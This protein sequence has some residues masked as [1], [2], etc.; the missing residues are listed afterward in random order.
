MNLSSIFKNNALAA[1]FFLIVAAC[2]YLFYLQ[3]Y[4]VA[5]VIL[6]CGVGA[7]FLDASQGLCQSD[8][9]L[10]EKISQV[11][12]DASNGMLEGRITGIDENSRFAAIAKNMN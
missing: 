6:V 10:Y 5:L 3:E 12:R 7:L 1:L 11:A 2:G 4:I 8:M 9:V